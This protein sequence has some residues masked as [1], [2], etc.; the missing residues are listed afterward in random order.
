MS[1]TKATLLAIGFSPTPVLRAVRA[2]C[3]DCSGGS[4]AEA[5]NCVVTTCQLY[6]FRLGANPW[7]AERS[8]AQ[9]EASRRALAKAKSS[10]S[11]GASKDAATAL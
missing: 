6:P 10:P 1:N 2:K 4:H 5:A 3:L 11:L 8:D 9:Q 7:R